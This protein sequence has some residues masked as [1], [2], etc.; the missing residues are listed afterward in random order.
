R[1]EVLRGI[2]DQLIAFHTLEQSAHAQ[3]IVASDAD[4]DMQLTQIRQGFASED[5]FKQGIAQQGLTLDQ[6]KRQA[7][8]SLEVQRL[9]EVEINAKV[10]VVDTDVTSFYQQNL[11]R[12]QQGETIHASHILI[13]VPQTADVAQKE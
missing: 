10:T 11:P 9:I 12:F 2:L 8:L 6:L 5:A 7:R 4:V 1:D 3:K 13:A